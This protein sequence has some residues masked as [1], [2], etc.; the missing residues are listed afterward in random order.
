MFIACL[1]WVFVTIWN[2]RGESTEE[3]MNNV[4]WEVEHNE[5]TELASSLMH[6][7]CYEEPFEYMWERCVM[8]QYTF[9]YRIYSG[10][11]ENG[12][13][14]YA[15]K[16]EEYKQKLLSVCDNVTYSENE[17]YVD[18]FLKYVSEEE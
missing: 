6:N 14:E 13:E 18:Y 15:D 2:A 4:D 12:C 8:D 1:V 3:R 5:F 11:V 17:P 16:A 7:E 9:L 10:A